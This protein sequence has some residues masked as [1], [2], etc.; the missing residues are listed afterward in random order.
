MNGSVKDIISLK[1]S[2]IQFF[3]IGIHIQ[4]S[5]ILQLK[6]LKKDKKSHKL[7]NKGL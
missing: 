3:K 4:I 7:K 2:L 5:I 6:K 1:K